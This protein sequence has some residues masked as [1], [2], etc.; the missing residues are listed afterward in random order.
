MKDFSR[1]SAIVLSCLS[2]EPPATIIKSV[3]PETFLTSRTKI[4]WAFFSKR[5]S[6]TDLIFLFVL[7]SG[8]LPLLKV[9]M[10]APSLI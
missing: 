7:L 4:L 2:D 3:I 9:S 5:R 8:F 6:I 1:L 10:P